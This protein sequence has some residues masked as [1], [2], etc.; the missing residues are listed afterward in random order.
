MF[1]FTTTDYSG[2]MPIN[3][4]RDLK[5]NGLQE[6]VQGMVLNTNAKCY[7]LY[8]VRIACLVSQEKIEL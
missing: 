3:M 1:W 5:V 7:H 2:V 6:L 8:N 4:V